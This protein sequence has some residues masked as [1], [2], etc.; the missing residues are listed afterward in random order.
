LLRTLLKQL[1]Q[2]VKQQ[3]SLQLLINKQL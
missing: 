2:F 3:Q 1:Y